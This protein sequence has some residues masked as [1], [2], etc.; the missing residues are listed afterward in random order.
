[1]SV[2]GTSEVSDYLKKFFEDQE[3]YKKSIEL[4]KHAQ[5]EMEKS[6][7]PHTVVV[8]N[9]IGY[10][11]AFISNCLQLIAYNDYLNILQTDPAYVLDIERHQTNMRMYE[12]QK[13][14]CLVQSNYIKT[15]YADTLGSIGS[16]VKLELSFDPEKDANIGLQKKSVPPPMKQPPPV[17]QAKEVKATSKPKGPSKKKKKEDKGLDVLFNKKL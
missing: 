5:L 8:D 6:N 9:K 15:R 12:E 16:L 3:G 13:Q 11:R 10:Q 14:K 2:G 4:L 1:M 7:G 17:V